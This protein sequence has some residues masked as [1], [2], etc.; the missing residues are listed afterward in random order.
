MLKVQARIQ[1]RTNDPTLSVLTV[2]DRKYDIN[3]NLTASS[4][5]EVFQM[6][7][8]KMFVKSCAGIKSKEEAQQWAIDQL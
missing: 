4:G 5:T 2:E 1:T 6:F 7:Q 3:Y 8:Y